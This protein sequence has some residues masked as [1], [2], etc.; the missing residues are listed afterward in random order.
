MKKRPVT[1]I[2]VGA[3]VVLAV[4]VAVL[5]SSGPASQVTASS[6]LVGKP[7]PAIKGKG[8]S[9]AG[10]VSGAGSASAA[11]SGASDV[12]LSQFAGKWV[13][14]NFAASWCVPCQQEMPQL[15]A[16]DKQHSNASDAVILTVAY[17]E[18][19][20]PSLTSFLRSWHASWPAVD[21]GS[22][23]VN[24]G[25]GG[26]PESY[27]VDPAGTVVAKYVGQINSAQLDAVITGAGGATA[28]ASAA[29]AGGGS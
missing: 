28:A 8:I 14:V 16:F 3:A 7:A 25:V 4:L 15:L 27:L 1:W 18:Q 13:L 2:A 24:Y 21:D 6:P 20:V 17:D 23:V 9:A 10:T 19:N 26:L 22:A 29:P 11:S 5:A 12:S